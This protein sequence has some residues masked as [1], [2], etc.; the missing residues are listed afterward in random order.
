[1]LPMDLA[2]HFP[3]VRSISG[4]PR[5]TCVPCMGYAPPLRRWLFCLRQENFEPLNQ[6]RTFWSSLSASLA[7]DRSR[8]LSAIHFLLAIPCFA[9]APNRLMLAVVI[10]P[11]R[12]I[13]ALAGAATL[14]QTHFIQPGR[15]LEA[16]F[17]VKSSFRTFYSYTCSFVSHRNHLSQA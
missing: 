7:C 13:T 16:E 8:R 14:S 2:V 3:Q 1:M 6:P 9:L 12:S 11:H 15:A 17:Q 4:L 5:F 10:S